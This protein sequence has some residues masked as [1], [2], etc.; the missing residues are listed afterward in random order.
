VVEVSETESGG[1]YR[2]LAELQKTAAILTPRFL[3]VS[4]SAFFELGSTRPIAGSYSGR[5]ARRV[6]LP[7][8]HVSAAK[9]SAN[10]TVLEVMIT[11]SANQRWQKAGEGLSDFDPC[12]KRWHYKV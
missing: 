5:R 4:L 8:G 1:Q 12:P 11:S 2:S 9:L 3:P 6:P 7:L 10:T